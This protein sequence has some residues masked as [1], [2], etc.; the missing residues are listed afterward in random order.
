MQKDHLGI[1]HEKRRRRF[2]G[3]AGQ[4]LV[5]LPAVVLEVSSVV[6]VGA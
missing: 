4:E 3:Q 1:A 2:E 6:P 5:A